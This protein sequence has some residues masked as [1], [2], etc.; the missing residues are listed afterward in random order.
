M[1][2]KAERMMRSPVM[3]GSAQTLQ[4]LWLNDIVAVEYGRT[5]PGAGAFSRLYELK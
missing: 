5:E 3:S 2:E 1:L 4:C